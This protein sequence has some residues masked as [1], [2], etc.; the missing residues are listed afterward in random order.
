MVARLRLLDPLQVRLEVLLREEGGAVDA[1][2]HLAALV[3]APV[4][5]GERAQLDRLDPAG[6]GTVRAAAEVL[7]GPVAVERDRLDAFVADK[8]LDQLDLVVLALGPEDLD[9][10]GDRDVAARE[11]LVG[12]D[13]GAHRL[14][15]PLQVVLG[16]P[17]VR[18][19][20]EVVVEAVLDRRADRHLGP[21]VQLLHRLG[22]HVGGVVADQLQG[23]GVAVGEDRDLGPV[24]QRRREVAQLAVDADRQRGLR[25][26][27][28]I[29]AA[30]SAPV[31]PS[32]S[33]SGVPSGS[34]TVIF[35]RASM[36][37]MLR[38]MTRDSLK[39]YPPSGISASGPAAPGARRSA[40]R[41]SGH[42]PGRGV[43]Q[44]G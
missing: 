27:G 23:L 37:P 36:R 30:A 40:G 35:G 11:L 42:R 9:R 14:L 32:G 4:G 34:L 7:E 15:D 17:D 3:A 19:E 2:Q 6:R 31:A 12:L 41:R 28:P 10:L 39:Q 13:V 22:H 25:Q 5:A 16:D 24:G 43:S 1:G 38:G 18:R 8:I 29:A 26:A 20:L 33:S 44:R 21:R